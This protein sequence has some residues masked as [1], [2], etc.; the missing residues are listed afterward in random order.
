MSE[1]VS[2]VLKDH[3]AFYEARPYFV[4]L[5]MRSP[6][7]QPATRKI[8][9]GFDVDVYG[10][11]KG[12]DLR[13]SVEYAFVC[14]ALQE[15]AGRVALHSTQFCTLEVISFGT[16]EVIDTK[17]HLEH[18][19]MVRIRITHGRGLSQPAGA[20]EES[21]LKEVESELERLGVSNGRRGG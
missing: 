12:R 16:S 4:L 13:P 6:T 20:A 8:H 21:A 1:N 10:T 19:A 3:H 11:K 7:G 14:A 15:V 5:E 18:D 17:R 9:A 2:S